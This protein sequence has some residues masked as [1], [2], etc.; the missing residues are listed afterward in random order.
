MTPEEIEADAAEHAALLSRVRDA[1]RR[2]SAVSA[3]AVNPK[4]YT[5]SEVVREP[6]QESQ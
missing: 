3:D 5:P 2:Y 1:S 4:P 6:T